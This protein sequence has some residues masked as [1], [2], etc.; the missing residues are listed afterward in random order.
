[1]ITFNSETENNIFQYKFKISF[2]LEKNK[3]TYINIYDIKSLIINDDIENLT[4]GVLEINNDYIY[5]NFELPISLN[6]QQPAGIISDNISYLRNFNR[7]DFDIELQPN[8]SVYRKKN[9]N[10]NYKYINTNIINTAEKKY[11]YNIYQILKEF[12]DVQ[13]TIL[14]INISNN[15]VEKK[16]NYQFI[17]NEVEYIDTSNVITIKLGNIL[18]TLKYIPVKL[19]TR[20]KNVD[21]I[22]N[23]INNKNFILPEN[24]LKPVKYSLFEFLNDY[25]IAI[26]LNYTA[27]DNI[28]ITDDDI[29]KFKKTTITH[30]RWESTNI[31]EIIY[32]YISKLQLKFYFNKNISMFDKYK[33]QNNVIIRYDVLN[34]P[35]IFYDIVSIKR[36][37]LTELSVIKSNKQFFKTLNNNYIIESTLLNEQSERKVAVQIQNK[38]NNTVTYGDNDIYTKADSVFYKVNLIDFFNKQEMLEKAKSIYIS[39]KYYALQ[40]TLISKKYYMNKQCL[41]NAENNFVK[42]I[43][44]DSATYR[45]NFYKVNQVQHIYDN[46]GYKC[47]ILLST[48]ISNYDTRTNNFEK[49]VSIYS[50]QYDDFVL[51]FKQK[52]LIT[53][54]PEIK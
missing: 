40:N 29:E 53:A 15:V 11:K 27:I 18:E 49:I 25:F 33:N 43:N 31:Y 8:W 6:N 45:F 22:N 52:T 3:N 35:N 47:K 32:Y 21:N 2:Q 13:I 51:N 14:H 28:F 23:N 4:S 26:L 46:D 42:N 39:L 20:L 44:N 41:I 7:N 12:C 36:G 19:N 37:D 48:R 5:T 17:I 54:V 1:M 10:F 50:N 24:D 16:L 30:S 38:N 9:N 34:V